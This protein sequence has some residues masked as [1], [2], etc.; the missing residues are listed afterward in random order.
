[1]FVTFLE[2]RLARLMGVPRAASLAMADTG[3]MN[4]H[5]F[6]QVADVLVGPP[7]LEPGTKGL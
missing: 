6:A 7:G 4:C 2:S 1:M 3:P 5:F